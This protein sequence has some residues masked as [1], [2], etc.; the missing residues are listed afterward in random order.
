MQ[1]FYRC[2]GQSQ[3]SAQHNNQAGVDIQQSSGGD[4][5]NVIIILIIH[6]VMA[7]LHHPTVGLSVHD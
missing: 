2:G 1:H 4:N 3:Q 6:V 5:I 7:L